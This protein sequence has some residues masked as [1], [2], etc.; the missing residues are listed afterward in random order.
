[1]YCRYRKG[2]HSKYYTEC[3]LYIFNEVSLNQG[4]F[5]TGTRLLLSLYVVSTL[6]QWCDDAWCLCV[7]T[8]TCRVSC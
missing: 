8:L 6:V 7:G 2:V 5:I 4:G 3:V 1:M